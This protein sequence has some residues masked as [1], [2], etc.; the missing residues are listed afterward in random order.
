MFL[1]RTRTGLHSESCDLS[2]HPQSPLVRFEKQRAQIGHAAVRGSQRRLVVRRQHRDDRHPR[3]EAGLDAGR[4]VLE[5]DAVRRVDARAAPRRAG[6]PAGSGLPSSTCSAV[7]STSRHRQIPAARRRATASARDPEVTIANRSAGTAST[8]SRAPGSARRPRRAVDL[9]PLDPGRLRLGVE[10]RSDEADQVDGR[11]GRGSARAR[12]PA[13]SPCRAAKRRQVC[14]IAAPE[15]TSTPSRSESTARGSNTSPRKRLRGGVGPR[16][17]ARSATIDG[18]ERRR[19]RARCAARPRRRR[20]RSRAGRRGSRASRWSRRLRCRRPP[21]RPASSRRRGRA[22]ARR[23][24]ARRPSRR[25][26]RAR[27]ASSRRRARA[28]GRSP[29]AGRRRGRAR[30]ARSRPFRRSPTSAA[31]RHRERE[32]G[33]AE[34]GHGG[35]RAERVRRGR[36]RS[37]RRRLPRRAA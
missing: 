24:R 32:A 19:S 3:R 34:R 25:S 28:R 18:R 23:R 35:R 33:V 13:S 22:P 5:H 9:L 2:F 4:G 30:P 27:R 14:S 8:S 31:R 21:A 6:S 29:R 36:R 1:V 20:S 16:C 11:A 26:R 15:S 7:T 10:V 12:A 37:S 17:R